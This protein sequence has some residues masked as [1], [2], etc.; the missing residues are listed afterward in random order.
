[1]GDR[2]YFAIIYIIILDAI[3]FEFCVHNLTIPIAAALI[4]QILALYPQSETIMVKVLFES[5]KVE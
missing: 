1:M 2:G 5:G 4:L 3:L